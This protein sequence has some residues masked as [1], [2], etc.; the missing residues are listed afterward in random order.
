MFK[1]NLYD[2]GL[3]KLNIL[4]FHVIILPWR[5][6]HPTTDANECPDARFRLSKNLPKSGGITFD[7]AIQTL[8]ILHVIH[9]LQFGNIESNG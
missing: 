1:Y 3:Y 6:F 8:K 5:I 4:E 7:E 9:T 2:S